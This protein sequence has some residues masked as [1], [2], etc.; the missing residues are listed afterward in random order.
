MWHARVRVCG[1]GWWVV[2]GSWCSGES[3]LC[4]KSSSGGLP[5]RSSPKSTITSSL[6]LSPTL[7]R[8]TTLGCLLSSSFS[9]PF[10]FSFSLLFSFSCSSVGAIIPFNQSSFSSSCGG[11]SF[12]ADDFGAGEGLDKSYAVTWWVGEEFGECGM[13]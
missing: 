6:A 4:N 5:F 3:C 8:L 2:L 7:T 12:G 10:S 13:F 11:A 1:C 9:S